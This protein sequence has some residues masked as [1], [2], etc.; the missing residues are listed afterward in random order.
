MPSW[1]RHRWWIIGSMLAALLLRGTAEGQSDPGSRGPIVIGSKNFAENRLLAEVMAQL[2]EAHTDIR[3]ERRINLGGTAV[4]FSALRSGDLDLY[5]EYTG[6]AWT[7]HLK[8]AER[9][10]SSLQAY[11]HVADEFQRKYQLTWLQPFGFSNSYALAMDEGR[12]N[13]LGVRTISDL[14]QHEGR[15][16]A[17]VSHE[18]LSREDGYPGLATAYGLRIGDLRGMEHGLAYEAIRS[19]RIDL[20]D[21][22]T[23]DGKLL[24]YNIRI[25]TD[26]KNFFPPYD[27]AP[28]ISNTAL[29][30][31]P[32]LRDLL[33]RLAFRIDGQ[34]MQQLNYRV[35]QEGGS[36]KEVAADFLRS[37]GLLGAGQERARFTSSR[38]EGFLAFLWARRIRTLQLVGEHLWITAIAVLLAIAFAVPLGVLLTRRPLLAPPV[39][40]AAGVIQTVPSL[41]LLAFMIPLP[42]LGLGARSAIA[43]LFLYALLPIVRNTFAGMKE[44]DTDLIEAARGMG[45]KDHQILFRVELPL[46]TRTI[47]AGIR[48]S[49]VISIGVATLAAF[50]GAGGL[51]DPIVTG[52][53]L[54]DSNLI[55]SGAVPAALLALIADFILGFAERSLVPRGLG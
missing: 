7:I 22:W 39:L 49:T 51:G 4:V 6:T 33:N 13:E 32:E 55:L 23:T 3:V 48:T 38:D 19:R 21:T 42:G 11:L 44:V 50:I 26:D 31:Y 17:G 28:L 40:G 53:Q 34:K 15:V 46:A 54:N 45:L 30:K 43:A 41:A 18:F 8:I 36:F 16:R 47:M 1:L 29:E 2:I 10:N 52:L 12:A 9:V 25:L 24:R 5:P 35:E 37:E 27:C 14:K 20:V